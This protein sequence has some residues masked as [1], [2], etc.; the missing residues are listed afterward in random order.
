[1]RTPIKLHRLRHLIVTGG[2]GYIGGYLIDEAL[3]AGATVT[4]L[5]RSPVP[6]CRGVRHLPWALG[7]E[8]PIGAVEHCVPVGRQA[9]VHLAHDW[10]NSSVAG[11]HAEG[12][13]NL[14]GTQILLEACRSR[15][16][17]RFVFVS[18]QSARADAANAYGRVKWHIEQIL[19]RRNE[20]S[21]RVGLVYGGRSQAMYGLLVRLCGLAPVLP[22]VEPWR[23]VQPIHV[24]EVA[25]GLLLMA[26]GAESGWLGLA[27]PVSVTFGQFL[28]TLAAELHG[29]R[30]IILPIPLK[31]ALFACAATAVLPFVPTVDTERVLGLVGTRPLPSA[32]HLRMLGLT[33]QPLEARLRQEPM[34]RKRVLAEGRSLLGYVLRARP[35]DALLRRY[36][37]A[38]AAKDKGGPLA[39]SLCFRRW[40]LLLRLT[41]PLPGNTPLARRLALATAL[42]EASPEGERALAVGGRGSRVASLALDLAVDGLLL[43]VRLLAGWFRQ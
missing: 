1:M 21:A 9:I 22:M 26:D 23:G 40:P 33:I 3:A 19:D 30:L 25:R 31:I 18:S 42:A 10:R 17:G 13:L 16:L 14:T 24:R 41:E 5:A 8:L 35:S 37:R 34:S 4:V 2:A 28:K 6:P 11:E 20:V 43:P 12:G 15:G 36:A 7:N 27:N 32:D 38:A 39:M 29:K